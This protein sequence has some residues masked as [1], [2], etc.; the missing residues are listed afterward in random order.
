MLNDFRSCVYYSHRQKVN[1]NDE[2]RKMFD[3]VAKKMG[4]L[5]NGGLEETEKRVCCRLEFING[6]EINNLRLIILLR[7]ITV[8]TCRHV[9]FR[10]F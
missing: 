9:C 10:C 8:C 6:A 4:W 2:T 7:E 3:E 1:M 5:D